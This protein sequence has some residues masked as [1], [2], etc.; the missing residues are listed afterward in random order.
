MTFDE[1]YRSINDYGLQRI[2]RGQLVRY[3]RDVTVDC[4]SG[5]FPHRLKDNPAIGFMEGVQFIAGT[6][7][8]APL[9][10]VA[11]GAKHELFG[12][13]SYY[14]PRTASQFPRVIEELRENVGTRRAV[15]MVAHP[16]DSPQTVPCTLSLQ[17]QKETEDSSTLYTT[18]TMRSSDMVW[19]MP[20]DIIQFS[21]V[22]Y[23]VARC[24]GLKYYNLVIQAANAHVY[25][26][27]A[28]HPTA[29]SYM[30]WAMP[31]QYEEWGAWVEWARRVV[32]AGQP[33]TQTGTMSYFR[34]QASKKGGDA[35]E[36][37]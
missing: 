35:N 12:L 6:S 18:V 19:G 14:G 8:L 31:E 24:V 23:A 25:D 26:L 10:S 37:E 28:V 4:F 30:H 9:K 15:I 1:A 27:T 11:P 36:K 5:M 7:E 34:V 16:E 29:W 22:S 20:Y 21:M 17:F 33:F 32:Y 3:D 13:N 2:V